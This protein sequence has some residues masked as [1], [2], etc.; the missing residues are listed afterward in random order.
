MLLPPTDIRTDMTT[1]VVTLMHLR[2]SNQKLNGRV[3]RLFELELEAL[4][5]HI[6]A[7]RANMAPRRR[8]M[9]ATRAG[10]W[11]T[12]Y[13]TSPRA[14]RARPRR[15]SAEL[16]KQANMERSRSRRQ[17]PSTCV[18]LYDQSIVR[19]VTRYTIRF[20]GHKYAATAL[21]SRPRT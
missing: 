14:T 3:D 4:T 9:A 12:C 19:F 11:E 10:R 8:R 15:S 6:H 7:C 2:F 21:R 16:L 17:R 18:L 20:Q 5:T 1:L 13:R